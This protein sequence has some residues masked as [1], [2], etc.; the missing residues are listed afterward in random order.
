MDWLFDEIFNEL[1]PPGV[2][3][4]PYEIETEDGSIERRG[5]R[6]AGITTA[7]IVK[8]AECHRLSVHVL[9]GQTKI[10]S[11]TL[12]DASTSVCLYVWGDHAFMVDDPHTKSATAQSKLIEPRLRPSTVTKVIVKCE[13]PPASE[14]LE[15][16]GEVLTGHFYASDLARVRLELHSRGLCPKVQLNGV[17]SMTS[18]RF[19]GTTIHRWLP[20]S[21][22]CEQFSFEF[23]RVYKRPIIHRGE[24]LASFSNSVFRELCHPPTTRK[25]LTDAQHERIWQRG[26]AVIPAVIP[27]LTGRTSIT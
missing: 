20:E 8:F 4:C 14:W 2:G 24:S 5:W 25:K 6:E 15:W 19:Q 9:W 27:R 23:E 1:Y 11:Y 22:V 10:T 16:S 18:L 13:D 12:L 26:D 21:F 3:D 7:I 17:G